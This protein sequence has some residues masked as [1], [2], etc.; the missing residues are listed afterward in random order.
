MLRRLANQVT[1]EPVA[2]DK[3]DSPNGASELTVGLGRG[4]VNP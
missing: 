2:G 3:N 1:G 4:I